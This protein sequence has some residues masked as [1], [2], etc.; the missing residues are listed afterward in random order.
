M[1]SSVYFY[2]GTRM[3]RVLGIDPGYGRVGWGVIEGER[4]SWKHVAHGCI[5]TSAKDSF[6]ARLN[7]IY[8]DLT[9]LITLY[10]PQDAGV[11]ELFFAKN[12][13]TAIDV[14]QARGVILLTLLQAKLPIQEFTPL[15]VK[16]A[17]TGYGK[18]EKQQ[19][20]KMVAMTLGCNTL[21]NQD[22]ALDALAVVITAGVSVHF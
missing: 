19:V 3:K 12:A 10:Q 16:Q 9:Q 11:E 2:L 5:E 22:D 6:V 18:A 17:L 21:S 13:K 1:P 8:T 14:A 20:Q 7:T 15:Q 4:N